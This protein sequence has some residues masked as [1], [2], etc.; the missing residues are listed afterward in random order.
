MFLQS[1]N[2]LLTQ[3]CEHCGCFGEVKSLL[4][5]N[6]SFTNGMADRNNVSV[7]L[8]ADDQIVYPKK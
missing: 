6:A 5:L 8:F 2:D 7:K 4:L 3:I 1:G